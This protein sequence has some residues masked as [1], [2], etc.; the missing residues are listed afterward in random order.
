MG[1][2]VIKGRDF[3]KSFSTDS[4]AVILNEA[5]AK[6][7]GWDDPIGKKI[8]I[9]SDGTDL[10]IFHVVGVVKDFNFESV[11]NPVEPLVL[12]MANSPGSIAIRIKSNTD[13]PSVVNM[14]GTTWKRFA[15]HQPFEYEFLEESLNKQ[16]KT[17]VRLGKILGIFTGLAFFVSCLG[18]FGLALFTTEQ[19]RKEIGIRKV[20]GSGIGKIIG[21]LSFDFTRLV[22]VAFIISCPAAYFI[23]QKWLENFAFRTGISWWIFVVT[24]LICYAVTILT[25][26]FQSYRAATVNPVDTL[27]SE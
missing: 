27:R 21:I 22:L 4:S 26:G 14:L 12:I 6:A 3:S 2:K 13:I 20:N 23:M 1:M 7:F 11:H 25:I 24:G 5:A 18:L 15:P 19:R 16:Y 17:E 10:D 8:G 9:P